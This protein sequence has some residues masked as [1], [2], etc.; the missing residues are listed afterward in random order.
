M[1]E[2]RRYLSLHARSVGEEG[3][4]DDDDDD[5]T[6]FK[7]GEKRNARK[8][9]GRKTT[10]RRRKWAG[11]HNDLCQRCG[12]GGELLCCDF[13][14][15]VYHM[16]C[17]RPKC[18]TIPDGDWACEN[19]QAEDEDE[20]G[21]DGGGV[22]SGGSSSG[23]DS[24]GSGRSGKSLDEG[25][26]SFRSPASREEALQYEGLRGGD[27][28]SPLAK[29]PTKKKKKKKME[30]TKKQGAQGVQGERAKPLQSAS[31]SK[32]STAEAASKAKA[33]VNVKEEVKEE[34]K[35][36]EKVFAKV[37]GAEGC[38]GDGKVACSNSSTG[39]TSPSHKG[40]EGA[41]VKPT[42]DASPTRKKSKRTLSPARGSKRHMKRKCAM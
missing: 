23:I 6:T 35:A 5:D 13:C 27:Y 33:K 1:P 37:E 12:L 20:E 31:A 19:C 39:S 11:P 7:K 9:K 25:M 26:F 8:G 4:N 3:D 28:L 34:V 24:S 30:Q 18:R 21:E 29:K 15:L 42:S 14:N 41:R 10:R 16:K 38:T 36:V 40:A 32:T 2:V 22:S 17:I